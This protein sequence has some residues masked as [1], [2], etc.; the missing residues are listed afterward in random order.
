MKKTYINPTMEVVKMQVNQMICL[1]A[2]LDQG[3]TPISDPVEFGGRED[4]GYDW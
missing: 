4:D 3:A 2:G 1:S